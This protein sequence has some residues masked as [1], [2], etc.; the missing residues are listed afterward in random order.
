MLLLLPLL[1]TNPT[2]ATPTAT[3]P[4]SGDP[5][6]LHP[7][8]KTVA[9]SG[10]VT[11]TQSYVPD[12]SCAGSWSLHKQ[13]HQYYQQQDPSQHQPIEPQAYFFGGCKGTTSSQGATHT[14]TT[15]THTPVWPSCML[16]QW[17]LQAL[18]VVLGQRLDQLS[19]LSCLTRHHDLCLLTCAA[20]HLAHCRERERERE[21]QGVVL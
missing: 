8:R 9:A 21:M 20:A 5:A 19:I 6:A 1:P 18:D 2:P 15:T 3:P 10:D 4:T 16:Y 17:Q 11:A 7:S 13:H 14:K 12:C